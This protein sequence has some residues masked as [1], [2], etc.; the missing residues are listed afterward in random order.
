MSVR[1]TY[2][3]LT[4][5]Y[6]NFPHKASIPSSSSRDPL[7]LGHEEFI[8]SEGGV[9]PR[10]HRWLASVNEVVQ[11]NTGLLFVLASQAFFASMNVAVKILNG[12]DPPITALEVCFSPYSV[13][14]F[15]LSDDH[16]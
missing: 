7:E 11:N 10:I 14:F 15:G 6:A 4:P 16:H 2:A 5:E 12:I 9:L 3:A 1:N 13:L 8:S